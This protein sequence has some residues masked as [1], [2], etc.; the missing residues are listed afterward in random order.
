[1]LHFLLLII[2]IPTLFAAPLSIQDHWAAISDP[3]LMGQ[4]FESRYYALPTKGEVIQKNKF[5]SGDYWALNKGN[6]NYRWH[7]MSSFKLKSPTR[8]E[9]MN[10]NQ[11]QLAQLSP[12]EK[13][14]LLNGRYEYPL[15]SEIEK[16]SDLKAK[17][18]EGICHGWAPASMNHKE[19]T[20]KTLLNP[21][22]IAV[23][24]GSSDIKALISHFYAS[25]Y[26]VADTH[27][28]GQRCSN[29]RITIDVDCQQDLNAGA[30]HIVLTNMIGLQ[31]EGFIADLERFKEVWNHPIKAYYVEVKKDSR[32]SKIDSA[33][34]T[35]RTINLM[36]TIYYTNGTGNFWET[37]MDTNRQK[38]GS[39][40][41]NYVIEVDVYGQIIGGEW[42]STERPDFLW[43]KAKPLYFFHPYTRLAELL[44]D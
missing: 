11:A 16:N 15:K 30:F 6:I 2:L 41:L 37:V 27:Q 3:I 14:D 20:A 12:A 23:P 1:M 26:Q 40:K 31:N 34:G 32:G 17:D 42:K 29:G 18:W 39:L 19:P 22:A 7:A 9:A 25:P 5:W 13:F 10:M 4:N 44:N 28:M 43:K 35:V 24:F 36:T 8:Q 33:P 38:M 21:D